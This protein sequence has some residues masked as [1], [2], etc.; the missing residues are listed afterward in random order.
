[1]SLMDA[2]Q[3]LIVVPVVKSR[4][5]AAEQGRQIICQTPVPDPSVR[6]PDMFSP[7]KKRRAGRDA[8]PA[9]VWRI[10]QKFKLRG[11]SPLRETIPVTLV[12]HQEAD[13]NHLIV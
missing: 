12:S 3:F 10:C 4:I 2:Q 7:C 6:L 11:R 9:D 1:M 5:T 13:L 8:D